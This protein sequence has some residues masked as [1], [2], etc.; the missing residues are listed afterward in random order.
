MTLDGFFE[1]A[2]CALGLAG[3]TAASD[4][5]VQRFSDWHTASSHWNSNSR[6]KRN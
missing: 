5:G 6:W 2:D 3:N 1:T 4:S